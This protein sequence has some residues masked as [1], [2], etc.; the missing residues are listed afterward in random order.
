MKWQLHVCK[1]NSLQLVCQVGHR[2]L[3]TSTIPEAS[4]GDFSQEYRD[5]S[6]DSFQDR[7]AMII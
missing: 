3:E 4:K 2:S 7:E 6:I 1:V 5:L